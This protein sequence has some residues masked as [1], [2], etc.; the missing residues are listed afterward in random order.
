M[1]LFRALQDRYRFEVAVVVVPL[2]AI[3]A[4]Q[5]VS[6]R[7]LA[8]VEVIASQTTVARYLDEVTAEV[9]HVYQD[10]AQEMLDVPGDVLAGKQFEEI[11]RHFA[12][13]DTSTAR[14]LFAGAL[15]GCLCLTRYYHPSTGAI[16]I[17]AA[18]VVSQELLQ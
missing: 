7:R 6:S 8:E 3:L 18:P 5:Y 10:A 14:F 11:A 13:T 1:R 15:D 4:L 17:G 9:R 2:L 12:R 16:E